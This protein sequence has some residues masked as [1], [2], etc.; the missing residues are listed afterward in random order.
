MGGVT[1]THQYSV[2]EYSIPLPTEGGQ[3]PAIDLM[4]DMSPVVVTINT[5]PPSILHYVVR[6]SAII[7]GV[8]TLAGEYT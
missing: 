6:I 3:N 4:Y 1:E 5:A 8:F 7:G 2:S